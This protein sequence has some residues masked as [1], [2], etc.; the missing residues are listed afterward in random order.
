MSSCFIQGELGSPPLTG[1]LHTLR[2]AHWF[3]A[4]LHCR[5]AARVLHVPLPNAEVGA[6]AA[7]TAIV[8]PD[9]IA[10]DF[11]DDEGTS[12]SA[13]TVINPNEINIDF[14]VNI[15]AHPTAP[16]PSS[17]QNPEEININ[18]DDEGLAA[19]AAS[20]LVSAA[21]SAS[22]GGAAPT[23]INGEVDALIAEVA[24]AVGQPSATSKVNPDEITL[25]D[26]ELEVEVAKP[27]PTRTAVVPSV[28]GFVFGSAPGSQEGRV[29]THFLALDKCLPRR[30]YLEVCRSTYSINTQL[31]LVG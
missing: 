25:D 17:L 29:E 11:D 7:S 10:I 19:H 20:E 4:H 15:P 22:A 9:E 6:P 8:N 1:L 27:A 24:E 2:P 18:L 31:T 5:Y 3:S 26:E 14:D 30:D 13:P 23:L 16:A 21:A 28:G 12:T